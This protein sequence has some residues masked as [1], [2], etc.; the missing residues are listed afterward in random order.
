MYILLPVQNDMIYIRY[1]KHHPLRLCLAITVD[2]RNNCEVSRSI[3]FCLDAC[4]SVLSR[5]QARANRL[6][7]LQGPRRARG[8]QE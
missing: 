5:V 8:A 4:V 1:K 6:E 3:V 7:K 2:V